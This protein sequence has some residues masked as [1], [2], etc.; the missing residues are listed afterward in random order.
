M[1]ACAPQRAQLAE[2][3]AAAQAELETAA[4]RRATRAEFA[5]DRA[6][7]SARQARDERSNIAAEFA[8]VRQV[9]EEGQH[10]RYRAEQALDG[11]GGQKSQT[12]H[13]LVGDRRHQIGRAGYYV[14]RRRRRLSTL[15]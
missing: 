10:P 14:A 4:E 8:R 5:A 3:R 7:E 12:C 9:L 2:T 13:Q 15:G 11:L 6:E 1:I